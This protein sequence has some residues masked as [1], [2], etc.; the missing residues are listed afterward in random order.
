M[1]QP[2][3]GKYISHTEVEGNTTSQ[4]LTVTAYYNRAATS[5]VLSTVFNTSTDTS[6]QQFPTASP[7]T[8]RRDIALEI[9]GNVQ[10]RVMISRMGR[11]CEPQPEALTFWD[12]GIVDFEFIQQLKRL[13][14]DLLSSVSA[15]LKIFLNGSTTAI[16]TGTV[17]ATTVRTSNPFYLTAGIQASSFRITILSS[18]AATFIPY[19]FSGFFKPL[20]V[21][22]DYVERVLLQGI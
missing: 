9:S 7:T 19:K 1:G 21:D 2:E 14:L 3:R 15:T 16:Y 8:A 12:S 10:A 18:T 22:Q 5:E 4:N 11:Y 17:S 20:G 6:V 13:Q